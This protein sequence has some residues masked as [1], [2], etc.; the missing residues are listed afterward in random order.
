MVR[1]R[2][3]IAIA[4]AAALIFTA[5]SS[6][7]K[8][9][10]TG[11]GSSASSSSNAP[12]TASFRGV[13]AT[14]IKIAIAD[15]DYDCLAQFLDITHG[16][17]KKVTQAMVDRI[18]NNGGI[19]GRKLEIVFS[20]QC[21][22]KQDE[23]AKACTTFTDDDQVFAVLGLYDTEPPGNG[24]NKLCLSKDHATIQINHIVKQAIIDQATP[25]LL[26][27]PD[28]TPERTLD[29]VL[30]LV[31]QQNTLAGK[32]IAL[33]ADQNTVTGA[34][35]KVKAA[36]SDLKLK[37]G[38]TAVLSI[39]NEET[40][41]AQ[42]QLDSFIE[43]WKT[44]GVNALVMAGLSVS[45]KQFVEKIKAAI[46]GM[47]LIT[48]STETGGQAQ[49]EV[50]AGKNPNP[51]EGMLSADG[52]S[53]QETFDSAPVQECV[54]AYEQATGEKVIAPNQLAAGQTGTGAPKRVEVFTAIED[55]CSELDLFKQIAEK[56]GPNL[57]NDTW[58]AAVNGFGKIKLNRS[59]FGS[60]H[61]GKYDADDAARLVA[62]DSAVPA[63][64]DFKPLSE[65]KDIGT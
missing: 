10:S 5:C 62:F 2:S 33:L 15:I 1:V 27:T 14:S 56:A 31:K 26:L 61:Q 8:A 57:T 4:L 34:E 7:K 28:R 41:A 21:P 42:A 52:P 6:D 22:L 44:E 30:S 51:Y 64:G 49:D 16:D 12:L 53:S 35:P 25:G 36:A 19:L 60:L 48:D 18:N 65:L 50:K 38:S 39:T 24:S 47:L 20:Q 43:K 17:I 29:A 46:P 32:T 55:R 40:T 59:P 37:Q 3:G 54:K 63:N 13:T 9:T 11:S 23:V 58:I 45:A